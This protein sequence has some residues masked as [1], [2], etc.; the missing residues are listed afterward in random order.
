MGR[1]FWR[2]LI[3][4]YY[5]QP[6]DLP[7][8]VTKNV[9]QVLRVGVSPHVGPTFGFVGMIMLMQ[10]HIE[11]AMVYGEAALAIARTV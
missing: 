4:A 2:A 8:V 3:G 11:M 9:E 1:L 6:G 5:S 7:L 10:G